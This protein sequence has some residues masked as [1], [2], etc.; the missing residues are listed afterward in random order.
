MVDV[1]E[2]HFAVHVAENGS[3]VLNQILNVGAM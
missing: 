3:R 2:D 1:V